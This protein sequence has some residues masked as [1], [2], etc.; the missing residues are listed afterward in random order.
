MKLSFILSK[1]NCLCGCIPRQDLTVYENVLTLSTM[2]KTPPVHLNK[3][4]NSTSLKRAT[5][6][7][8]IKEINILFR[9]SDDFFNT[10]KPNDTVYSTLR[11]F[12]S[13]LNLSLC[14]TRMTPV[15]PIIRE[16]LT[17][18]TLD[19][20]QESVSM[21]RGASAST[22]TSFLS[23][24]SHSTDYSRV[25]S[26]CDSDH[27][28]SIDLCMNSPMSLNSTRSLTLPT[29]KRASTNDTTTDTTRSPS[30][31][32]NR[33]RLSI[34]TGRCLY[35]NIDDK[36]VETSP[37]TPVEHDVLR[38]DLQMM[39]VLVTDDFVESH[40]DLNQLTSDEPLSE[41]KCDSP[42]FSQSSQSRQPLQSPRSPQSPSLFDT[43]CWNGVNAHSVQ[44]NMDEI[45]NIEHAC[46]KR[47]SSN[48][49]NTD[50]FV[51]NTTEESVD[52]LGEFLVDQS[53]SNQVSYQHIPRDDTILTRVKHYRSSHESISHVLNMMRLSIDIDGLALNQHTKVMYER[54]L[55]V[56]GGL[57]RLF[58]INNLSLYIFDK[59]IREESES[60]SKQIHCIL[61]SIIQSSTENIYRRKTTALI[62]TITVMLTILPHTVYKTE[63]HSYV[64]RLFQAIQYKC[65]TFVYER[66]V[67]E[68]TNQEILLYLQNP[69]YDE[70]R[71][72][73]LTLSKLTEDTW[74]YNPVKIGDIL[75]NILNLN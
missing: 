24:D 21:R 61:A 13:D 3:Y 12:T 66:D 57:N 65:D 30:Y 14:N 55:V 27:D 32:K 54:M 34:D 5:N 74:R 33:G 28:M 37:H 22:N 23:S 25:D 52:L 31:M 8:C 20:L 46:L 44:V 64:Y 15:S 69:T 56:F 38:Q 71:K 4:V 9:E 50:S 49:T 47:S 63:L 62:C 73:L 60:I 45:D 41:R 51:S 1:Y 75:N 17:P 18:K 16:D 42:R 70:Y 11:V 26:R 29:L 48:D 19:E 59:Q 35:I 36:P 43:L 67:H 7:K 53:T 10:M 2:S 72:S 39:N 40:I 58:P 68:R 6:F